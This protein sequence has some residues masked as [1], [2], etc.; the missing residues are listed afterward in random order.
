MSHVNTPLH[1]TSFA[2]AVLH[3]PAFDKV[4]Q[5]RLR[6]ERQEVATV[7]LQSFRLSA[8]D[9]DE[10]KVTAKYEDGVLTLELPKKATAA[11]K[12]IAIQ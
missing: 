10:A 6:E 2:E 12:R 1:C 3:G 7:Q 8:Q 5:I 11:A 4:I 9:V